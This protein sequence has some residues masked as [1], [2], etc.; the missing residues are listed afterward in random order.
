MS[1]ELTSTTT[2][3]TTGKKPKTATVPRSDIQMGQVAKLAQAAW[4]KRLP[5]C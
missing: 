3:V 2:A 4:E 5:C 1:T